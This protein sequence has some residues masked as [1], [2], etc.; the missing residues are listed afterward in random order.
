MAQVDR[1]LVEI[2][3]AANMTGIKEAQAGFLGMKNSLAAL[4]VGIGIA[5]V[6]TKS[7]I[8]ITEKHD[9]AQQ[10]LKQATDAQ[11]QSYDA[12]NAFL[13]TFIDTNRDYFSSQSEV[14]SGYAALLRSGVP[15]AEAQKDMG[16]ALDIAALKGISV[17]DATNLMIAAEHGRTRGLI[18]LGI[19]TAKY[20]DAQGN[21]IDMG[22]NMAKVMEEVDK[23]TAH[24]RDTL[25]QTAKS[26]N[27]LSNDWQDIANIAGPPLLGLLDGVLKGAD[28]VLR[29]LKELGQNKDW[30]NAMNTLWGG[31]DNTIVGIIQDVENT[32]GLLS[33]FFN[34]LGINNARAGHGRILG[35]GGSVAI[36]GRAGGVK[37]AGGFDGMVNGPTMFLAGEAGSEHVRITP[38]GG[39]GGG[40]VTVVINGTLVTGPGWE[41]RLSLALAQRLRMTNGI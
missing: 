2:A 12:A 32:W 24:G 17:T 34:W 7:I 39:G 14:V 22:K 29:K 38:H 5:A 36:G 27:D 1:V 11:G 31:I 9:K 15:A 20:T 23:K 10:E 37:A 28:S 41:D 25:T 13:G 4:M 6:A 33:D 26:S 19:T 16:R 40:G 21:V 8:D 3:T 35:R 30:A 18:D